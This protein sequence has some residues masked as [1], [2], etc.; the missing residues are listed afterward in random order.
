MRQRG[1]ILAAF[2]SLVLFLLFIFISFNA[3]LLKSPLL[4]SIAPQEPSSALPQF[5]LLIGIL[6][7]ADK[8]D[9]RHFLRLV[10]GIQSSPVAHIDVK[11]I[12]L[13]PHQARAKGAGGARNPKV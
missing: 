4:L 6:T 10:Y 7:R 2:I 9:R 1:L 11:F 8:Y 5:S 3:H 13:Q 12:F